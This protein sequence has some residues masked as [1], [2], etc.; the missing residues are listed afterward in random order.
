MSNGGYRDVANHGQV[1]RTFASVCDYYL[2]GGTCNVSID[3]ADINGPI[4]L[5]P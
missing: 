4:T 5:R 1:V 3:M 2:N